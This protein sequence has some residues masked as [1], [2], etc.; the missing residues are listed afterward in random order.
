MFFKVKV[1]EFWVYF[2]VFR[3]DGVGEGGREVF[4]SFGVFEGF[5]GVV[6]FVRSYRC[7]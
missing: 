7:V 6:G 1:M 4:G 5:R 3:V 2:T